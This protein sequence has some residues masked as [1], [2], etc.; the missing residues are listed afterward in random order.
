[1][2]LACKTSLK[3]LM[4]RAVGFCKD[5]GGSPLK[6]LKK[7]SFKDKLFSK[8]LNIF[9][10]GLSMERIFFEFFKGS[11]PIFI[12]NI[13]ALEKSFSKLVLHAKNIHF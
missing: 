2:F 1:M 11:T 8:L 3:K 13:N 7:N 10:N 6:T 9:K 4:Q 12:K 5:I